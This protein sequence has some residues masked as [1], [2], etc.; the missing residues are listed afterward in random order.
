MA[1]ATHGLIALGYVAVAL[2]V[3]LGLG[4]GGAGAAP[5]VAVTVGGAVALIGALTHQAIVGARRHRELAAGLRRIGAAQARRELAVVARAD[6]GLVGQRAGER[7]RAAHHDRHPRRRPHAAQ[8]Q[9]NDQGERDI[10]KGEQSVDSERHGRT[11]LENRPKNC[12]P[13]LE[14]GLT[15]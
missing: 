4:P 5:W 2:V 9:A 10:A 6:D 3:G 1:F 7:D 8:G 11:K 12:P 13:R 14:R 15:D